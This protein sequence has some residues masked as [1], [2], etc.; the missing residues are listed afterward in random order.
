[1]SEGDSPRVAPTLHAGCNS[2]R[3]RTPRGTPTPCPA[4][5]P[6]KAGLLTGLGRFPGAL[7]VSTA[8]APVTPVAPPLRAP[9]EVAGTRRAVGVDA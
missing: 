9:T 7:F 2:A 5:A 6:V 4:K 1:M 3:K 8:A